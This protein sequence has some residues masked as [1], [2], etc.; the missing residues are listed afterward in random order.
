MRRSL[1]NSGHDHGQLGSAFLRVG[2][3][4]VHYYYGQFPLYPSPEFTSGFPV[5][6]KSQH[7]H[8]PKSDSRTKRCRRGSEP[9][10]YGEIG[11]PFA[12]VVALGQSEGVSF[13]RAKT[14]VRFLPQPLR[15]FLP[16]LNSPNIIT[17]ITDMISEMDRVPTRPL[18]RILLRPIVI[19]LIM[20]GELVYP[21]LPEWNG[22]FH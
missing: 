18:W 4:S 7:P 22:G 6:P 13:L 21:S 10:V 20:R 12:E 19:F 11:C 3:R 2:N 8:H 9:I 1:A 5:D 16:L 14:G 17:K 15:R